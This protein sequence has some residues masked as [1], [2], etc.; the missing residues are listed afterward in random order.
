MKLSEVGY[1]K[2][3]FRIW[4]CIN[5]RNGFPSQ[6]AIWTKTCLEMDFNVLSVTLRVLLTVTRT[7]LRESDRVMLLNRIAIW[8]TRFI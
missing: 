6:I 4:T 8:G 5:I 7:V 2:L 3:G 1:S